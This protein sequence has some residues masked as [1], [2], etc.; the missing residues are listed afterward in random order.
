MLKLYL[1]LCI[2]EI[3]TCPYIYIRFDG[4]GTSV[5][6]FAGATVGA[7]SHSNTNKIKTSFHLPVYY[8]LK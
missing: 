2:I 7:N 8:K 6:T 3:G 1:I 4:V 5:D